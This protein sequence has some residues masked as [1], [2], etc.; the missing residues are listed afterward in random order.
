MDFQGVDVEAT[1]AV[2]GLPLLERIEGLIKLDYTLMITS[3]WEF[4]G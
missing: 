1:A 2:I 3:L 4:K